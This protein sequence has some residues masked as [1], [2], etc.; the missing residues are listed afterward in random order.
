MPANLSMNDPHVFIVVEFSCN[1]RHIVADCFSGIQPISFAIFIVIA[2]KINPANVVL[3]NN[4][5]RRIFTTTLIVWCNRSNQGTVTP[6]IVHYIQNCFVAIALD[7]H[8]TKSI[9]LNKN[10]N[11]QNTNIGVTTKIAIVVANI[12]GFGISEID[13]FSGL[14]VVNKRR[15]AVFLSQCYQMI[16]YY[17]NEM[18]SIRFRDVFKRNKNGSIPQFITYFKCT[19]ISTIKTKIINETCFPRLYIRRT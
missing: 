18:I 14:R 6:F 15:W 8:T 12:S 5:V 17:F 19:G 10:H 13:Q 2:A 7:F 4:Q 3:M 1:F 9:G 16:C 11:R